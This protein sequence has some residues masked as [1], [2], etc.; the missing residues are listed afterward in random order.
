M[1]EEIKKEEIV[2]EKAME[3]AE[4]HIESFLQ[5]LIFII[6]F[7]PYRIASKLSQLEE[8]YDENSVYQ[9]YKNI[10]FENWNVLHYADLAYISLRT[11][12]Q[13]L[14]TKIDELLRDFRKYILTLL[15]KIIDVIIEGGENE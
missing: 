12:D 7:I 8:G 6:P 1:N 9:E 4:E 2:G 13:N 10:N 11:N 15:D 3:L 5:Y 14:K